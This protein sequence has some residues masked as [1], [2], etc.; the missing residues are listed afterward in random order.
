VVEQLLKLAR[1]SIAVVASEIRSTT[2]IR[3]VQSADLE[4]WRLTE[5]VGSNRLECDQSLRLVFRIELDGGMQNREP[6]Q[7]EGGIGG[8][9]FF[10]LTE[11]GVGVS[12]I[13]STSKGERGEHLHVSTWGQSECSGDLATGLGEI[14]ELGFA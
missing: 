10:Q 7:L 6:V 11:Q 3:S 4:R 8:I 14:A 1:G 13:A 5:F 2:E 9:S 12:T